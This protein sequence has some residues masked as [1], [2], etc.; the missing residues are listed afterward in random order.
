MS[1]DDIAKKNVG[2][3]RDN[4]LRQME[5]VK[6]IS[7]N[8]GKVRADAQLTEWSGGRQGERSYQ[9]EERRAAGLQAWCSWQ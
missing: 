2:W 7:K 3:L 9:H 5:S 8:L 1:K 4:M 6:G